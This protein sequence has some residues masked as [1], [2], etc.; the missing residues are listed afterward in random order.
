MKIQ[1]FA[2]LRDG[3]GKE[4]DIPWREGMDGHAVLKALDLKA[5]DVKIFLI[6]GLHNEPDTIIEPDDIIALFPA[7]GGG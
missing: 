2:T 1:L 4:V 5:G 6:N 7:V 3:R